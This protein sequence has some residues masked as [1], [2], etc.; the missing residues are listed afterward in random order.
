VLLRDDATLDHFMNT[1]IKE[2]LGIPDN[3]T[4]GGQSDDVFSYLSEDFMKPV[5]SV[6]KYK[7]EQF[8]TVIPIIFIGK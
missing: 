7:L 1:F 4:W 3:V 6:G 2:A 5:T 8:R